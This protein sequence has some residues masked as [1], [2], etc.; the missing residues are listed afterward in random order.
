MKTRILYGTLLAFFAFLASHSGSALAQ[1]PSSGAGISI[2]MDPTAASLTAG[3]WVTINTLI[4]NEGSTDSPALVA[5]LNV[6]SL[7]PG[8]HVDPED[9]SPQRT[10]YVPAVHPGEKLPLSWKVH[11]LFEG[12]F[13]VYVSLISPDPALSPQVSPTLYIHAQPDKVLPLSE[14]LPVAVAVPLFPF[15]FLMSNLFKRTRTRFGRI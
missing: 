11:T 12:D 15:G 9:W 8:R 10:Q 6:A 1:E 13:A 7:Q 2:D 14:V 3:E 5:H 4:R